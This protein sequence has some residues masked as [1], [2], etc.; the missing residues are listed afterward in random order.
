MEFSS[1]SAID[2]ALN[3][4]WDKAIEI[5]K[6]LLKENKQDLDSMT[7][8]AYA[9][10]QKGEID[11]A[12]KI[13]KKIL[14]FDKYNTLAHKNLSK[15]NHL[16]EG[17]KKPGT[18]QRVPPGLFI[19]EPGKTK[20]VQLINLAPVKVLSNLN[21]GDSVLLTP[22]KHS[23][24]IRGT[25]KTYYGALPD[26]ISFRLIKFIN[27]G[28]T[29]MVCIKNIQKNTVSVFIRELQRGKK[30]KHQSTFIP[31]SVKDYSVSIT[32]E[33]KKVI[34]SESDTEDSQDNQDEEE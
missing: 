26:D 21:I 30:L 6:K 16:T 22:K 9:H 13:Y 31:V 20:T 18:N 7:R 19:E 28:N 12:K 14:S 27:A 4:D 23:V 10:S 5:N 29:Y 11:K 15:I 1:H 3:R 24:E 2:A 34:I 32:R 25:D 17:N 8:L 33:M